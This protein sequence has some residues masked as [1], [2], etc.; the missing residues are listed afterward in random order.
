MEENKLSLQCEIFSV[1]EVIK[2]SVLIV[3]NSAEKRQLSIVTNFDPNVPNIV[4]GDGARLS[5]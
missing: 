4:L 3:S 1:S 5:I 2:E